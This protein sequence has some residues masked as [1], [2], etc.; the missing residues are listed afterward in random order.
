MQTPSIFALG[1]TPVP[2]FAGSS[3]EKAQLGGYHIFEGVEGASTTPDVVIAATGAEVVIAI[4]GAK[5]LAAEGVR[6][7]VA[8]LPCLEVFEEQTL[9]YR[10]AV[11]P[12]GVPVVSVEASAIRGWERYAHAHVGLST[13]GASAPA[14]DVLKY[15][16]ITADGVASKAKAALGAYGKAAP[17]LP[18]NGPKL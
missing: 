3:F 8:S 1:R 4:D 17:I 16:G 13:F 15:F 7:V 10:E 5:K 14:N 2:N 11:L 12:R 9:E 6:A 18:V